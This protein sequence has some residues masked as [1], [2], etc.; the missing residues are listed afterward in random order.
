MIDLTKDEKNLINDNA[1]IIDDEIYNEGSSAKLIVDVLSKY[2][3]TF[4]KECNLPSE[5]KWS[6]FL[7]MSYIILDWDL[8]EKEIE[9]LPEG[10]QLGA[11]LIEAKKGKNVSFIK[12]VI[13]NSLV[14]IFIITQEDTSVI[15][16]TLTEDPEINEALKK[17]NVTIEAKQD[18]KGEKIIE[19]LQNW[20]K[21]NNNIKVLKRFEKNINE[22][23][24]NLF[25]NMDSIEKNWIDVVKNT[26]DKDESEDS[27][28]ELSQ[29]ITNMFLSR[30]PC[31]DFTE[32]DFNNEEEISRE[33]LIKIYSATKVC[34]IDKNSIKAQHLGDIYMESN[35]K[36]EFYINIIAECDAR[37]NFMFLI[38]CTGKNEK[39]DVNL[40]NNT[41]IDRVNR[42]TIP[43]LLDKEL[44]VCELDKVEKIEK[45]ENL[46]EIEIETKIYTRVGRLTH[47][48]TTALTRKLAQ[49]FSRQG[50]PVH[51]MTK[52]WP[53]TTKNT[54]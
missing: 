5:E 43:M 1:A 37:K 44:I 10:V 2:G 20:I 25:V 7:S 16:Q 8:K 33:N 21:L 3:T 29:F 32:I 30:L 51:P 4:V 53:I 22:T 34:A 17:S 40:A 46:D 42:F 28:L 38:H 54:N 14:P 19:F 9:G 39:K 36:K 48:Y 31:I 6:N 52:L 13:S 49:Y 41:I 50:L 23:K 45:P 27:K 12:Y 24:N 35:E 11:A 18:V 15:K 47:P 26:I